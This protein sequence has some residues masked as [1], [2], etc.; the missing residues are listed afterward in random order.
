MVGV[1]AVAEKDLFVL[2][3]EPNNHFF[4]LYVDN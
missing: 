1:I 4:Q 3:L 2:C